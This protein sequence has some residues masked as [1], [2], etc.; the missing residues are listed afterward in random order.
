MLFHDTPC[1]I[2]WYFTS[3]SV[4][5]KFTNVFKHTSSCNRSPV[6][7]ASEEAVRTL[8][9]GVGAEETIEDI[10]WVFRSIEEGWTYVADQLER[11]D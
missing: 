7:P 8:I 4:E 11:K 2:F 5:C 3:C 9:L 1:K 10:G 6:K